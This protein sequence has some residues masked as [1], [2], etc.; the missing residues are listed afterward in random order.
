MVATGQIRQLNEGAT[1]GTV[2]VPI[3]LVR[4]VFQQPAKAT[5]GG[6]HGL[7]QKADINRAFPYLRLSGKNWSDGSVGRV[8]RN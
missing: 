3:G 2:L 7:I 1:V 6:T 5:I 8:S 4:G